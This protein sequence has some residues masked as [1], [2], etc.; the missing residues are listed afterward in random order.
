MVE[1]CAIANRTVSSGE[2]PVEI[3]LSSS[4]FHF[5]GIVIFVYNCIILN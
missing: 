5:I 1:I 2:I 4:I 3:V